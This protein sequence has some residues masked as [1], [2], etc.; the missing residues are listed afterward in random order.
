M[1]HSQ[2]GSGIPIHRSSPRSR[3]RSSN[4]VRAFLH[5]KKVAGSSRPIPLLRRSRRWLS[6]LVRTLPDSPPEPP[7]PAATEAGLAPHAERI[8]AAAADAFAPN[9]RRAYWGAWER[10]CAWDAEGSQALLA[11]PAAVAAYLA[12]R[13]GEGR[14]PATL[15][16]DRQAIRAAR[17]EAGEPDPAAHEG[18]RRVMRGLSRKAGGGGEAAAAGRRDHRRS[19]RRHLGPFLCPFGRLRPPLARSPAPPRSPPCPAP[20]APAG[21][22]APDPRASSPG[23]SRSCGAPRRAPEDL[24]I[25]AEAAAEHWG[26][27]L[28]PTPVAPFVFNEDWNEYRFD[29]TWSEIRFK[30]GDALEPGLHLYMTTTSNRST[31]GQA[32]ETHARQFGTSDVPNAQYFAILRE[33][34]EDWDDIPGFFED[35]HRTTMHE[36]AHVLGVGMGDRWWEW[37][38]VSDSNNPWNVYFTHPDAI[39]VFDRMGGTDFPKTTPK[40]PVSIDRA[41]WDLCTGAYDLITESPL[42]RAGSWP[43]GDRNVRGRCDWRTGMVGGSGTPGR[44]RSGGM[45]LTLTGWFG[46]PKGEDG[47]YRYF[48]LS[49]AR[50]DRKR[51]FLPWK[52]RLQCE[53]LT[54][55]LPERINDVPVSVK[56]K[57]SFWSTCPE[58]KSP[59]SREDRGLIGDWMKRRGYRAQ[60][61]RP[62]PKGEPP[63]YVGALIT[64]GGGPVTL[65]VLG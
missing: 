29:G 14:S 2:F 63:K 52:D 62:W 44:I 38:R 24:R 47:S 64:A 19:P 54:I 17:L 12:A 16:M 43:V 34:C 36:V 7:G 21:A 26:R 45:K 37:L 56:V 57:K 35:L 41:H 20:P 39:A 9:T 49:I 27:I 42:R 51:L 13:S 4:F 65:R 5:P 10:F 58:F 55:V 25:G 59:K 11:P 30:A 8:R 15:R 28:A 60:H 1:Y 40:I 61:G 22:A 46:G 48:G 53:G 6:R 3:P 31:A 32:W 18:V 50:S 33:A 23:P